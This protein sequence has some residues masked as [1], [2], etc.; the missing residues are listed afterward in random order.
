MS[1]DAGM[2]MDG[3]TE[4]AEGYP[5]RIRATEG[6]WRS[7][8]GPKE[9]RPGFGRLVVAAVNEGGHNCTEVD[10]VE[11]LAWVKTHRPDLLV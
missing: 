11:L 10:L 8:G 2:I 7:T 6:V 3:V 4:Y 9:S 5:V 1:G